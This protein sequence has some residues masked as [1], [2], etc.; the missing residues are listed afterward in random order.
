MASG[1][2]GDIVNICCTIRLQSHKAWYLVDR[3]KTGALVS[4][5]QKLHSANNLNKS[6]SW[7]SP[8]VSREESRSLANNLAQ[9]SESLNRE[10]NQACSD[11]CPIDCEIINDCYFKL[12][13]LWQWFYINSLTWIR[14]SSGKNPEL[15]GITQPAEMCVRPE[16]LVGDEQGTWTSILLTV[17]PLTYDLS[18]G[19]NT[20]LVP[21]SK[22]CQ[23]KNVVTTWK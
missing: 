22:F 7:F 23:L 14:S 11:F 4:K 18:S 5:A 15:L 8:R 20:L 17:F 19:F 9:P 10:H 21:L 6:R 3:K 1:E 12:L 16:L 2:C 13:T